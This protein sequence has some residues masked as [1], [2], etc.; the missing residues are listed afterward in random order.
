MPPYH[1]ELVILL[2][3][4]VALWQI[5][6][7]PYLHNT[8]G[9]KIVR[10]Q[11][12]TPVTFAFRGTLWEIEMYFVAYVRFTFFPFSYYIK[13]SKSPHRTTQ[14][15]RYLCGGHIHIFYYKKCPKHAD[16]LCL[17]QLSHKDLE[18]AHRQQHKKLGLSTFN[19]EGGTF[20]LLTLT[21]FSKSL[22]YFKNV[23]VN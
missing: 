17:L 7:M 8:V 20:F 21:S 16:M 10:P 18:G 6:P 15:S 1:A 22:M 3:A 2:R 13:L 12:P 4:L 9:P 23:F 5:M 14:I 11:Y 19:F